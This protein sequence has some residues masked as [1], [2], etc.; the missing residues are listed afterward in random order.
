MHS[1]DKQTENDT[2][3]NFLYAAR[4]LSSVKGKDQR[5]G[6]E[7]STDTLNVLIRK[8]GSWD[9]SNEKHQSPAC[10]LSASIEMVG[11]LFYL[12]NAYRCCDLIL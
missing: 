4:G 10:N 3:G 8:G 9:N 11:F 7:A 5:A 12:L 1:W 2:V 6:G